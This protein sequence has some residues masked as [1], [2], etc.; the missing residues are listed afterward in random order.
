MIQAMILGMAV[1]AAYVL[2]MNQSHKPPARMPQR[3]VVLYRRWTR[4][5]GKKMIGR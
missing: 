5:D 3:P 1:F 2:F 4:P